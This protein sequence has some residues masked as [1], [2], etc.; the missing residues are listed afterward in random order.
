MNKHLLFSLLISTSLYA[1]SAFPGLLTFTQQD[2]SHFQGHLKGDEW[3]NYISLPNEYIALY[4]KSTKNYEYA[5]IKEG[6]LSPSGI[7]VEEKLH[8]QSP[9][10]LRHRIPRI[11]P[12]RLSQMHAQAYNKRPAAHT[13]HDHNKTR[14]KHKVLKTKS[15]QWKE[16][17]KEEDPLKGA[18]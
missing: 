12:L 18:D 11:D 15:T 14:Y 10:Q 17:L 4:N 16:I 7:I 9:D 2:G 6:K 13:D 8:K 3:F 5:L 1:V